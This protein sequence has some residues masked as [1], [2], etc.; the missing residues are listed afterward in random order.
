MLSS[1][2]HK[3]G[4]ASHYCL[5]LTIDSLFTPDHP[6]TIHY[7]LF[8]SLLECSTHPTSSMLSGTPQCLETT[9]P[10]ASAN[11]TKYAQFHLHSLPVHKL[12]T[13]YSLFTR[14]VFFE[15][16]GAVS[17]ARIMPFLL[18]KSR[19]THHSSRER[20]YHVFYMLVH[21]TIS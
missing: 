1:H 21:Y 16:G 5:L 9:T 6:L 4:A 3:E 10:H 15:N 8:R 13:H 11:F 14:K 12:T 7:P 17:G 2:P 18:E 19:V 20:N